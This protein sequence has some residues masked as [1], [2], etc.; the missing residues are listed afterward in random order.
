[1]ISHLKHKILIVNQKKDKRLRKNS[2]YFIDVFSLN[3]YIIGNVALLMLR[4]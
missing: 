2:K 3:E 1:M 4:V